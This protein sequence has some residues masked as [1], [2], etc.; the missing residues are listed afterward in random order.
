MSNK[1]LNTINSDLVEYNGKRLFDDLICKGANLN[2]VLATLNEILKTIYTQID[3]TCVDLA[4]IGVILQ[5]CTTS[6]QTSSTLC[7]IINAI[8][9]AIALNQETI[10]AIQIQLGTTPGTIINSYTVKT[11]STDTTPGYL[12]TK[13]SSDQTGTVI[14]NGTTL[15]L[16]GFVPIGFIGFYSGINKFDITGKGLANTD[17]WGW[18]IMNGQNGTEDI[19]DMFMLP[20]GSINSIGQTGGSNSVVLGSTNIPSLTS[21]I[22][23]SLNNSLSTHIHNTKFETNTVVSDPAGDITVTLATSVDGS[24]V[25]NTSSVDQSHTHTSA[26][27]AVYTNSSPASVS[28]LP[29]Y[30]KLVPIKLIF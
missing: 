11:S 30:M 6:T 4:S 5:S 18:A 14:D 15:K 26:L 2:E 20:T 28:T 8:G 19:R 13:I 9:G 12:N 25:K 16:R 24:F 23:G 1:P 27:F 10:N 7:D 29:K 17:A 21:T 22:T 3:F